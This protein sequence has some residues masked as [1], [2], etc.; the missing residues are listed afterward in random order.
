MDPK[1]NLSAKLM[2]NEIQLTP[3]KCAYASECSRIFLLIQVYSKG[4]RADVVSMPIVI[5]ELRSTFKSFTAD[6]KIQ[7]PEH[8]RGRLCLGL[9]YSRLLSRSF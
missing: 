1:Q 4:Y 5:A 6:Y 3:S 2:R 7:N 9:D 8:Y